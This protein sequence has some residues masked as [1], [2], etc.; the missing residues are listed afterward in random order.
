MKNSLFFLFIILKFVYLDCIWLLKF[1]NMKDFR[2][3]LTTGEEIDSDIFS[4]IYDRYES[5]KHD[6][7]IFEI[8]MGEEEKAS[9]SSTKKIG[10]YSE[11]RYQRKHR[12]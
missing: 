10:I 3:L 4:P 6:S 9:E 12:K 8:N 2:N 5:E 11:K 7:I 1:K